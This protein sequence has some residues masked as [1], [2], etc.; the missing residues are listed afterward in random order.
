VKGDIH[1]LGKNLVS[2]LLFSGGF[3]VEDLG[4]DVSA[5]KFAEAVRTHKPTIV[6]MSCLL[7]TAMGEMHS[8]TD[9]LK[10]MGMRRRVKVLVGGRPITRE[11]A[12]EIGADGFGADAI[13]AL[14]AAKHV[15]RG[16]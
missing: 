16:D 15:I 8:T 1:D 9:K 2:M 13:Q 4:V 6:A 3:E 7:T 12:E 11:F 14:D 5:E 10:E